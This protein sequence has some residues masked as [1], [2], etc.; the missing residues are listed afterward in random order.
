VS[1]PIEL[2]APDADWPL[3]FA[4][5]KTLI[6]PLFAVAPLAI[7]HMG[8]T[9]VPG[10][11]AKPVIDII[12]LVERL[13]EARPAITA[14]EAIGYSFWAANPDKSKFYLA[15]G[16]P[17]APHRTHHLHIHDDAEEVRRHLVFRDHL[18]DNPAAREA[19][20]ALKEDLATRFRDDRE[21]YSKHKTGFV[22][23]LVLSLGGPARARAWEP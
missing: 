12:V 22:D 19:Y 11:K 14:L 7:E 16:L 15:K 18:R 2:R 20:Q 1:E 4:R 5:E 10:L 6:A 13:E 23:A 21:A 3:A 17:P 9:A 8:S